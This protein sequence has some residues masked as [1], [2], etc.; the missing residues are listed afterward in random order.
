MML[1]YMH[2]FTSRNA[3]SM[4]SS[5]SLS[6]LPRIYSILLQVLSPNNSNSFIVSLHFLIANICVKVGM[7]NILIAFRHAIIDSRCYSASTVTTLP[8][9][10]SIYVETFESSALFLMCMMRNSRT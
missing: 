3:F 2:V 8:V 9:F 7:P 10:E 5:L 6:M 4:M 1:F